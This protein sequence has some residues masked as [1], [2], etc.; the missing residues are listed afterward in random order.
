MEGVT[1]ENGSPPPRGG[2][3][4]LNPG[5]VVLGSAGADTPV[6]IP[7]FCTVAIVAYCGS[8]ASN[9]NVAGTAAPPCC[10]LAVAKSCVWNPG[11]K[12]VDELLM[13]IQLMARLLTDRKSVV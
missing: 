1:N 3:V 10:T 9:V 12:L 5:V 2:G 6:M 7:V 13:S 8:T 11:G 4:I